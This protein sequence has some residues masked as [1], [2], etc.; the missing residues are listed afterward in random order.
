MG[1]ALT[2]NIKIATAEQEQ[3]IARYGSV[4]LRAFGE[5]EIA[6]TNQE[7]LAERLQYDQQSLNDR[8]ESVRIAKERYAAGAGDLLTLLIIQSGQVTSQSNVIKLRAAQLANR[9]N[10]HLALGGGFDAKPAANP[11]AGLQVSGMEWRRTSVE[12]GGNQVSE[13]RIWPPDCHLKPCS[14]QCRLNNDKTERND[15]RGFRQNIQ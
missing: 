7:L 13:F 4:V 8:N 14:H 6:L 2:A 10:L 15:V 11:R 5:V 9:I 1:G 3:T 12:S